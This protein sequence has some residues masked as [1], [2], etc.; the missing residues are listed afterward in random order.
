MDQL[1]YDTLTNYCLKNRYP[2]GA[3]K[4]TKHH[5]TLQSKSFKFEGDELYHITK[6]GTVR[7]ATRS[8]EEEEIIRRIHS[9][10]GRIPLRSRQDNRRNIS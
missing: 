10:I 5:I 7:K 1:E 6:S 9:D 3:R 4:A 8:D 2:D